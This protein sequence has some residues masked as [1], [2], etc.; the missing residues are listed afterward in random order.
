MGAGGR[1]CVDGSTPGGAAAGAAA[2]AEAGAPARRRAASA[3]ARLW[4]IGLVCGTTVKG[5]AI[6]SPFFVVPVDVVGAG[7]PNGA[8]TTG[9]G[10]IP[11]GATGAGIGCMVTGCVMGCGAWMTGA[12]GSDGLRGSGAVA[13]RTSMI[14]AP[15]TVPAGFSSW[16]PRDIA[17]IATAAAATAT[18]PI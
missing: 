6:G 13:G 17:K 3:A 4:T 10:A 1:A 7:G 16:A 5:W 9:C 15:P 8:T 18:L 2:E 14:E 11:G 12:T